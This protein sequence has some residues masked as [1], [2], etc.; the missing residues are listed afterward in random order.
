MQGYYASNFE[1]DPDRHEKYMTTVFRGLLESRPGAFVDVG[2]NI[3][4]SFAKVLTVGPDRQYFCFEP[5]IACCYNLSQFI[6]INDLRSAKVLPVA[7]S[8]VNG[9]LKFYSQGS[10]DEMAGLAPNPDASEPVDTFYVQARVGDEVLSELEI[11]AICAIKI[12]VEGAELEVLRGLQNT[13]RTKRPPVVF[14]VRPNF[15]GVEKRTMYP[16]EECAKRQGR[17]DA[18]YELLADV[19]YDI[20]QIDENGAEAKI[21]RF[22]LDDMVNYVSNDYIARPSA[23]T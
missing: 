16:P 21:N 10:Y 13:L 23:S 11:E 9:L 22:E 6:L 8:D 7:L 2:V 5:Q 4:Q 20:F 19:R 17:A 3:G 12:D 14:E 18:I 1:T 15:W